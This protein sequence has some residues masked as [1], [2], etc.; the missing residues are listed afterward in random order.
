M[1]FYRGVWC[2]YCNLDL[3]AAGRFAAITALGAQLVA[4]SPDYT[5]RP[6][7]RSSCRYSRDADDRLGL[8]QAKGALPMF[9]STK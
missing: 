8:K 5:Q 6:I 7:P 2:P 3:Q 9:D 4:I 1:T